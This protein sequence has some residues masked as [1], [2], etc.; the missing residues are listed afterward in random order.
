[1]TSTALAHLCAFSQARHKDVRSVPLCVRELWRSAA[2][3]AN[4][5]DRAWRCDLARRQLIA[6]AAAVRREAQGRRA[7]Q[8]WSLAPTTALHPIT[9]V[10]QQPPAAEEVGAG[11]GPHPA[12]A[13]AAS[14]AA[15][16][17]PAAA[18][19]REREALD[20][21]GGVVAIARHY[22]Q[23]WGR[24]CVAD[25][26][27]LTRG[28]VRGSDDVQSAAHRLRRP[29]VVDIE[30]VAPAMLQAAC[31]ERPAAVTD[32]ISGS[33]ASWTMCSPQVVRGHAFGKK[34][35]VPRPDQVRL[36][37][38]LP[39]VWSLADCILAAALH[40]WIDEQP[41]LPSGVM[42][43]GVVEVGAAVAVLGARRVIEKAMDMQST[44]ALLPA[45]VRQFYDHHSPLRCGTHIISLGGDA[46]LAAA[47]VRHQVA[48]EVRICVGAHTSSV[49]GR[50]RGALTGLRVAG[51]LGRLAIRDIM[52]AVAVA[53]AA[54]AFA[55]SPHSVCLAS[56][57]DN[58]ILAGKAAS[59]AE[60]MYAIADAHAGA[61]S[62]LDRVA[63]FQ[64]WAVAQAQCLPR[65]PGEEISAFHRRRALTAAVTVR[66]ASPHFLGVADCA[67]GPVK[68]IGT[69]ACPVKGLFDD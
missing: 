18:A 52:C 24:Q 50:T 67:V 11:P 45:D 25:R 48:P 39:S 57:V 23:K 10:A 33:L 26:A 17:A 36:I 30:G 5:A 19:P 15:A 63:R 59:S 40:K 34:S 6:R 7:A 37:L 32:S 46:R 14:A 1:M 9:A 69:Q 44:G 28:C 8:G 49:G 22:A 42:E 65:Y 56:Y 54:R 29:Y 21:E 53:S 2:A 16:V 47:V 68:S 4:E 35:S 12:A 43:A 55:P 61:A 62:V 58:L 60:A 51:A 38:P 27:L 20:L 13:A 64:R 3:Q 66:R 41:S 31:E